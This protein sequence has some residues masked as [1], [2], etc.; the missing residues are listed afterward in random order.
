MLSVVGVGLVTEL[1]KSLL[2]AI[3]PSSSPGALSRSRSLIDSHRFLRFL[4]LE[5]ADIPGRDT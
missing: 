3:R 4:R 1:L 2:D 5:R